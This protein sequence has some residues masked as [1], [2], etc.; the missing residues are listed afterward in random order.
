MTGQHHCSD[1]ILKSKGWIYEFCSY[2]ILFYMNGVVFVLDIINKCTS[3]F[4]LDKK[5]RYFGNKDKLM[6]E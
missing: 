5:V 4:I 1:I 3:L 2:K 6:V